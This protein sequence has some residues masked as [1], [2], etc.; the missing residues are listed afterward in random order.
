MESE[1]QQRLAEKQI[2]F[3]FN[4]PASLHFGGAWERKIQSNKKSLQV[5]IGAQILQEEVLLTLLF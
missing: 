2:Q 3:C 4:P 1:L 5:V